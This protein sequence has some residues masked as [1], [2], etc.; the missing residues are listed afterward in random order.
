MI[1][2]IV[3]AIIL[4]LIWSSSIEKFQKNFKEVNNIN[5]NNN[6]NIKNNIENNYYPKLINGNY[7]NNY[8]DIVFNNIKIS[9]MNLIIKIIKK[10]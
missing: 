1:W 8:F 6:S 5:R 2:I 3:I 9:N 10:L 4:L 7:N